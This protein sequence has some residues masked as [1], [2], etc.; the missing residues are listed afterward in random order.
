MVAA[1]RGLD[2]VGCC[3]TLPAAV[4]LAA[5]RSLPATA[6]HVNILTSRQMCLYFPYISA[7]LMMFWF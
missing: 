7:A 5:R 3:H 1:P 6:A 2:L 4:L